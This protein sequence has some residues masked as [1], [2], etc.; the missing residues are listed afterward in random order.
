MIDIIDFI[1]ENT[2]SETKELLVNEIV[3]IYETMANEFMFYINEN[4][5]SEAIETNKNNLEYVYIY[6]GD[7]IENFSNGLKK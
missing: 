3:S 4:D 1:N 6:E 2:S 5:I 7:K